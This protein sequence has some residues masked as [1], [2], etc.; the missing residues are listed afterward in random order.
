MAWLGATQVRSQ[1]DLWGL[2]F[3]GD[4]RFRRRV[5]GVWGPLLGPYNGTRFALLPQEAETITRVSRMRGSAG[6][7]LNVKSTPTPTQF[8]MAFDDAGQAAFELALRSSAS[9]LS[10]TAG[11]ASAVDITID[12][13]GGWYKLPHQKLLTTPT[14]TAAGGSP[15]LVVGDAAGNDI[16]TEIDLDFGYF[17]VRA[18]AAQIDEDDVIEATYDYDDLAGYTL[19]GDQIAENII[20]AEF[21]GVAESSSI[22]MRIVVRQA[23]VTAVDELN[24]VGDE[25][26][27]FNFQG[28]MADPGDGSEIYTLDWWALG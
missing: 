26:P 24:V 20:W 14:F 4:L 25:F 6:S 16:A 12:K 22:A 27:T 21:V 1:Q 13:K 10:Q 8:G 7:N 19:D 11:T 28:E 3:T 15:A 2:L 5:S 9:A 17:F 18:D 23:S